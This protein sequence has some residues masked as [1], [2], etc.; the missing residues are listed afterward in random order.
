MTAVAS[1]V[2]AAIRAI[3]G[4]VKLAGSGRLKVVAPTPLPN[5]LI[6]QLR[7][8]KPDLISLLTSTAPTAQ[9]GET[10]TDCE[11]E[12]AAVI[13]FDGAAPRAWAEALAR[14]DPATR[15]ATYRNGVGCAS[16]TTAACSSTALGHFVR[17]NLAGGRSSCSA[18]TV[19]VHLL[20]SSLPACFGL[21]MA[22][23]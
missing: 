12:R 22:A 14:L 6:E 13:E 20:A 23:N 9:P 15:L 7:A 2:L 11:E 17:R 10:R 8:V 21:S 16:L 1:D 19:S 5:E 4:D 18:A 3:G